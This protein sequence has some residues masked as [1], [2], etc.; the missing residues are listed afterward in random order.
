MTISEVIKNI[1][2]IQDPLWVANLSDEEIE[3]IEDNIYLV[4]GK[5]KLIKEIEIIEPLLKI[6]EF[7][8]IK[9]MKRGKLRVKMRDV[10]F[11]HFYSLCIS[12]IPKKK[13]KFIY[14]KK[15]KKKD[16]DYEFL[17]LL[18]KDKGENTT[19]CEEYYDI[20]EELGILENEKVK[21]FDKYGIKYEPKS[22]D[23]IE[24]VN[25]NS[26]NVHPKRNKT[27]KKS[28]EYLILLEKIKAFGLLEPII[29]QKKTNYVVCGNMRY[30]CC[31]E[32]GI[33]RI[34][35]IKKEFKFDVIDL[36]NFQMDKG[37]LLSERVKEYHKLNQELK[38]HGYKERKKLMGGILKRNY[39]FQETG[40]SQTLVNRLENIENKDKELYNNVLEGKVSITKAYLD[41][42]QSKETKVK[43]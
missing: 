41:L 2:E 24:I 38:K 30:R 13:Y 7:L 36:I 6:S 42:K 43:G 27:N 20:Y 33:N 22:T 4:W 31:K 32:L 19:H 40:I 35:V 8:S 26:I 17:K 21:L 14:A 15:K 29:V 9:E 12:L 25:I 5:L 37:K 34:L 28:K 39:L 18:A 16:Y 11:R 1:T 10:E 23:I 3:R